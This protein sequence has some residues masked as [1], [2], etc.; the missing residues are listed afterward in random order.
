MRCKRAMGLSTISKSLAGAPP[1]PPRA[2]TLHA[3]AGRRGQRRQAAQLGPAPTCRGRPCRL[4]STYQRRRRWQAGRHSLLLSCSLPC[5]VLPYGTGARGWCTWCVC[6]IAWPSIQVPLR[7][8][9]PLRPPRC[10]SLG[11]LPLSSHH[12]SDCPCTRGEQRQ[13]Q[14]PTASASR[15]TAHA[16]PWMQAGGGAAGLRRRRALAL[17]A[18]REQQVAAMPAT[19]AMNTRHW[20]GASRLHPPT[21]AT[22][23]AGDEGGQTCGHGGLEDALDL[24]SRALSS[25]A[26]PHD[27]L[28]LPAPTSWCSSP[29]AM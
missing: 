20:L 16:S 9:S 8:P 23:C 21:G 22:L 10:R 2:Q 13:R 15:A 19:A 11:S 29:A 14:Q 25:C 17:L 6:S 28:V 7:P 5:P 27:P 3:I 12:R 4:S 1:S 18:A 26:V 24:L